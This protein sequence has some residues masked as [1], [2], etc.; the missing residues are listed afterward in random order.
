MARKAATA[1]PRKGARSRSEIPA[2][3]L[4]GLNN[5]TLAA[6]NLVEGLAVDFQQLLRTIAPELPPE[7][8]ASIDPAAGITVRMATAGR[9]L[10]AQGGVAN[11]TNWIS[12]SSDTV[13]G[14]AAYGIAYDPDLTLADRLEQIRP[15]A[16]DPHFGVR[17]WAWLAVRPHIAAEIRT[18]LKLLKP[19]TAEP[20]ENLRRFAVESTRP[21][22]VWC[23]HID[24]LKT[25]PELALP[26][27]KP[28]RKDPAK[29]VQDSVANWLNDAAR[30][31]P[32]WVRAL[33]AGW[34]SEGDHPATQRICVRAQRNLQ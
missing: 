33:C 18:A 16:D 32:D 6:T 21:R 27:L 31:Q 19:W 28:L 11:L 20:S 15:L 5:G 14:W 10:H 9:I 26:L 3:I 30:S 17:E 13:R 12:H 34:L 4:Q 8:I 22:G 7:A 24:E 25:T 23:R 29:Y 1:A 2:E